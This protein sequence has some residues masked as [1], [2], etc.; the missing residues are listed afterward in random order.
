MASRNPIQ[1]IWMVNTVVRLETRRPSEQG[2]IQ[3]TW[4][5]NMV[6][7]LTGAKN[8]GPRVLGSRPALAGQPSSPT[9]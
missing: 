8:K 4:M 7:R 6:D 9:R 1:F 2:P 5:G 3:F